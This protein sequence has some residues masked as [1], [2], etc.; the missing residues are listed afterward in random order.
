MFKFVKKR[1]FVNP[2]NPKKEFP[3]DI[4]IK[5]GPKEYEYQKI[6]LASYSP[7]FR[8]MLQT[9]MLEKATGVVNMK[10]VNPGVIEMMLNFMTNGEIDSTADDDTISDLYDVA[11]MYLIKDLKTLCDDILANPTLE[12]S[13]ISNSHGLSWQ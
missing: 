7:V 10:E 5:V 8:R 12:K 4:K 9:D 6:I 2:E 11:D 1:S 13:S 3:S